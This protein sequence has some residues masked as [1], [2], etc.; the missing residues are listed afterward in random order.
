MTR[1][2]WIACWAT[3][4]A[5]T[6]AHPRPEPRHDASNPDA[7]TLAAPHLALA[8]DLDA[9]QNPSDGGEP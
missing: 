3:L 5:C 2:F 8:R 7:P 4:V 1:L 6:T 9:R